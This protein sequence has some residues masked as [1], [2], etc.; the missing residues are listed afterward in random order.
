VK[1]TED[2]SAFATY[3]WPGNKLRSKQHLA[4]LFCCIFR[5]QNDLMKTKT[6]EKLINLY[7]S[8]VFILFSRSHCRSKEEN[9]SN[10][11]VRKKNAN[12]IQRLEWQA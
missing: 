1:S 11:P 12:Y 6:G 10:P 9:F 7:R 8:K 3:I 2:W 5:K 4:F